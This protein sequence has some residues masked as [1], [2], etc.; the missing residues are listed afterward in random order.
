MSF[1]L[2]SEPVSEVVGLPLSEGYH[3]ALEPPHLGRDGAYHPAPTYGDGS[4]I[5]LRH[6][7]EAAKIVDETRSLVKWKDG[8]VLVLDVS[9]GSSVAASTD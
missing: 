6:L 7:E 8:D 9:V 4:P 5:E 1:L 3:H 2:M